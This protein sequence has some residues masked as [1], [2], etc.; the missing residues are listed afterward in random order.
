MEVAELCLEFRNEGVVGIDVACAG[1]EEGH[2]ILNHK[3]AFDVCLL[4]N[5]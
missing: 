5:I 4:N 1:D 3:E 2:M